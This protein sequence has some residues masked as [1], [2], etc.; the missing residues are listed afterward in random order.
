MPEVVVGV[1]LTALLGGLLVPYLK[2]YLDRRSE[3]FRSSVALVDTLASSLWAYWKLALR[4]AYYG[5]QGQRG[6][7]DLDLALRRWDGDDAWQ[8]GCEIQIQVSRSKR[9]LPPLAQQ[10]LDRAQQRVV[11][12]LDHEIDR[13][14]DGG[15]P[16]EWERL[17]VSLMTEKR[18]EIDLLLTS[19][20]ADLKLGGT[21]R[22]LGTGLARPI[23][24]RNHP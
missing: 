19:V 14:R 12:Y 17:Y 15:T 10:K 6:A 22:K 5:R 1:A 2:G 21:P 13:L 18:T 24:A 3:Q 23:R 9:L 20:T 16:D 7:D 8:I 11:D 4:V